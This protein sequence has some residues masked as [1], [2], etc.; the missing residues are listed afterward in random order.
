MAK[1]RSVI[2]LTYATA[3]SGAWEDCF[4]RSAAAYARLAASAATLS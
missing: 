3:E 2:A 4:R 1:S